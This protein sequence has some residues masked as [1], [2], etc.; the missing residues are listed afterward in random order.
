MLLGLIRAEGS[1]AAEILRSLGFT[2]DGLHEK[3]KTATA[4]QLAARDE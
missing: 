3:V 1:P 2:S 4:D